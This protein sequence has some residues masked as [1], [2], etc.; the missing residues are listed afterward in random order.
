[1][2]DSTREHRNTQKVQTTCIQG[3]THTG[4]HRTRR[5]RTASHPETPDNP[6]DTRMDH[7]THSLDSW[8]PK[9]P[10]V[11]SNPWHRTYQRTPSGNPPFRYRIL[12]PMRE[13]GSPP[14]PNHRLW[15]SSHN[16][17]LD[18]YQNRSTT[19]HRPPLYT[20]RLDSPPLFPL[21]APQRQAAIV[22]SIAHLV[23]YRMQRKK[24]STL[25]DYIDFLRRAKWK[26]YQKYPRQHRVG[27]YLDII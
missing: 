17:E 5:S 26:A 21:L 11:H 19:T 8:A 4:E 9:I 6:L 7:T 13:N 16:M 3:I 22:W 27:N 25:S 18:P 23:E 12:Q 14:T 10:M 1:M 24:R 2:C 15:W 20:G